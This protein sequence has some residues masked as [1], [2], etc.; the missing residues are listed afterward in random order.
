MFDFFDKLNEQ[1][2]S[3]NEIISCNIPKISR[4]KITDMKEY[5]RLYYIRNYEIYK[6]R[7][8]AYRERK[9]NNE[10]KV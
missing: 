4:E 1:Y 3:K 9:K 8:E 10:K 6:K 5:K 7:N 2:K